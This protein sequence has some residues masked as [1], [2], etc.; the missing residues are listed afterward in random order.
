MTGKFL[1][2]RHPLLTAQLFAASAL[3][4]LSGCTQCLL[5]SAFK[6]P[7]PPLPE[8]RE[9]SVTGLKSAKTFA[10]KI[11]LEVSLEG[12]P[13]KWLN[14]PG[15]TLYVQPDGQLAPFAT[16]VILEAF[17][18]L[19]PEE[20]REKATNI[21][22]NPP[23]ICAE[24]PD[25][26]ISDPPLSLNTKWQFGRRSA[27]FR[28]DGNQIRPCRKNETE[29]NLCFVRVVPDS[30]TWMVSHFIYSMART[31]LLLPFAITGDVLTS[32]LWLSG[33][34]PPCRWHFGL[35]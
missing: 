15:Q 7:Q 3:L 35:P 26:F 12:H 34:D 17:D 14:T 18:G 9:H 20:I 30:G 6:L 2:S 24:L 19:P 1:R 16:V 5:E 21:P 22:I 23:L 28:H 13:D 4:F 31:L 11:F 27:K 8:V 10:G 25:L 32:P 33:V 29:P